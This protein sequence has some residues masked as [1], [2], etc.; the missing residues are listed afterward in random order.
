MVYTV[1]ST[2]NYC[3]L[4]G[5]LPIMHDVVTTN[6][7][8]AQ[9]VGSS[10][11]RMQTDR[12]TATMACKLLP[13]EIGRRL[14]PCRDGARCP[15]AKRGDSMIRVLVHIPIP[16]V[17]YVYYLPLISLYN[18]TGDR[19]FLHIIAAAADSPQRLAHCIDIVLTDSPPPTSTCLSTYRC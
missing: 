9:D 6:S 15:S 4:Q 11:L 14:C 12:R 16:M 19:D 1:W 3:L 5:R 17:V 8:R 18:C 2:L 13:E 7:K 10:A